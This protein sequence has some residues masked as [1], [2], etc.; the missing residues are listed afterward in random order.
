MMMVVL[1]RRR[2]RRRCRR[3]MQSLMAARPCAIAWLVDSLSLRSQLFPS[4]HTEPVSIARNHL[5]C[6]LI[7]HFEL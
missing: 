5:Q 3:I 6:I 4:S 2:R 1:L 7:F